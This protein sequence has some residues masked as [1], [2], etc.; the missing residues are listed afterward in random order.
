M[1][2]RPLL[3]AWPA[4]TYERAPQ[5]GRFYG[6]FLRL[7]VAE[8]SR[9]VLQMNL[10]QLFSW[11][12]LLRFFL[13]KCLC[14]F[15]STMCTKVTKDLPLGLVVKPS[16]T[17]L[18]SCALGVGGET[19]CPCF[20]CG[21]DWPTLWKP[22]LLFTAEHVACLEIWQGDLQN[23]TSKKDS[24]LA[25]VSNRYMQHITQLET[26]SMRTSAGNTDTLTLKSFYIYTY[27]HIRL[28]YLYLYFYIYIYTYANGRIVGPVEKILLLQ[29][30]P[31]KGL[32]DSPLL[33]PV[34]GSIPARP[35]TKV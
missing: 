31:A 23:K 14:L 16:S 8:G 3:V 21:V 25:F 30:S 1:R 18:Q 11:G 9:E 26:Q 15:V 17:V 27:T 4:W 24:L 13:L 10:L 34:A 33:F 6:F 22:Y 32:H 7:G 2:G 35:S 12:C 5:Q 20:S 19:P 28:E 29:T